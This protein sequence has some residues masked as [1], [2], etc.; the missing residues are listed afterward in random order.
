MAS[1]LSNG[2]VLPQDTD[3]GSVF[4]TAIQD[5][6]ERLNGHS[7]D[8]SDSAL[9]TVTTQTVSSGSWSSTGSAGLY[10]QQ[11]DLPGSLAFDD[12]AIEFRDS[13]GVQVAL[14]VEKID[15]D[16]YYVYTNDNSETYTALYSS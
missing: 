1:T 3:A 4:F 12:I 16:S 14:E 15:S 11:V 9:L 10:R 5:N 8:G 2:Y 7:H 6:I 13:N